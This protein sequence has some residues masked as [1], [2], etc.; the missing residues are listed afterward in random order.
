MFYS[1][2]MQNMNNPVILITGIMILH[3]PYPFS[4]RRIKPNFPHKNHCSSMP[5]FVMQF[6]LNKL[7]TYNYIMQIHDF[8]GYF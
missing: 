8:S 5:T 3:F 1:G 4:Q 2:D 6:T 7:Y